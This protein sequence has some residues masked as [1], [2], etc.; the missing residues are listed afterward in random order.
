LEALKIL[1]KV[2]EKKNFDIKIMVLDYKNAA[3]SKP[4]LAKSDR[5]RLNTSD[6]PL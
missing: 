3:S 6:A 4:L 2:F 1:E 5:R